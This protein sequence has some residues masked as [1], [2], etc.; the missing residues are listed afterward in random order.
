MPAHYPLTNPA[1]PPRAISEPKQ[2]YLE[3]R[4]STALACALDAMAQKALDEGEFPADQLDHLSSLTNRL[5]NDLEELKSL[6]GT[7]STGGHHE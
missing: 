2:L 4:K 3:I 7:A 5:L 6:L 1:A